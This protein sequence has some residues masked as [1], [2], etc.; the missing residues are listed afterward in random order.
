M[1]TVKNLFGLMRYVFSGALVKAIVLLD[2]GADTD[3]AV[4]DVKGEF[5]V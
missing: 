3:V 2:P 4:L 1:F 5:I